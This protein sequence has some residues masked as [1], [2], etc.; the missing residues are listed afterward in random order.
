LHGVT[1]KT[2]FSGIKK[3]RTRELSVEITK[4]GRKETTL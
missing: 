1:K 2:D 3:K 4:R